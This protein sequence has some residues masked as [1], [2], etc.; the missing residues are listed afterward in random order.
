MALQASLVSVSQWVRVRVPDC[1]PEEI[2]S[3]VE[4]S[5]CPTR[6]RR[7]HVR[8]V[9]ADSSARCCRSFR[10]DDLYWDTG[11]RKQWGVNR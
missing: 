5:Q 10:N 2:V 4:V 1:V 3:F 7:A 9:K 6:L 11:T 8:V